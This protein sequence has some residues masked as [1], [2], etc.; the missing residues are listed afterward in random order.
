MT[1]VVDSAN[2]G[3]AWNGLASV[4]NAVQNER[5]DRKVLNHNHIEITAR[6][7]GQILVERKIAGVVTDR[8]HT[9]DLTKPIKRDSKWIE[10]TRLLCSQPSA[11]VVIEMP[12]MP[13]IEMSQAEKLAS[14]D[15]VIEMYRITAKHRAPWPVY[16]NEP[17]HLHNGRT[18]DELMQLA[19]TVA[20]SAK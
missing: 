4:V 19:N 13:T 8:Y 3:T 20:A 1:P 10:Q 16:D 6:D 9:H 2:N 5:R 18:L 17:S 11:N 12:V 14:M 7:N 15:G